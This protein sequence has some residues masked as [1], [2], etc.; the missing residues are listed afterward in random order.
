MDADE[1]RV[2]GG[3][4]GWH[5][6]IAGT[7]SNFIKRQRRFQKAAEAKDCLG[8]KLEMDEKTPKLEIEV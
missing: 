5:L 8:V 2:G 6:L 1:T 3:K 7:Q 4:S